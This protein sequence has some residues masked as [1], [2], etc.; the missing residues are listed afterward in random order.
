M[1]LTDAN[2]SLARGMVQRERRS[3]EALPNKVKK[4]WS[5]FAGYFRVSLSLIQLKL[6]KG[7]DFKME[8]LANH[9]HA[10]KTD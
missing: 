3:S 1:N 4:K 7:T 5:F 2:S 8:L 6:T 10:M 9:E